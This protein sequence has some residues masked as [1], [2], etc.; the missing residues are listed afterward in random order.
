MLEMPDKNL[1]PFIKE[2]LLLS[3]LK[4]CEHRKHSLEDAIA[5]TDTAIAKVMRSGTQSVI[6]A[7][8]LTKVVHDTLRNFDNVSAVQYAALHPEYKL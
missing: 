5:L 4:C 1:R 6:A 3:I 2:R 7:H 8:Q